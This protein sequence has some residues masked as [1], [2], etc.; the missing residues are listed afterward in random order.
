M[1]FRRRF[2]PRKKR[3]S[4]WLALAN[5]QADSPATADRLTLPFNA[6]LASGTRVGIAATLLSSSGI[7]LTVGGESGKTRRIV[8]DVK[9]SALTTSAGTVTDAFLREAIMV[10]ERDSIGNVLAAELDLF[11]NAVLGGEDILQMR[12]S[13]FGAQDSVGGVVRPNIYDQW[14]QDAGL[15]RWDT[16]VTRRL[17]DD[18]ILVYVVCFKKLAQQADP[19]LAYTISGEL[20]GIIAR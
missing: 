1:A 12:E 11:S 6:A 10:A 8:G 19:T 17:D 20:R 13:Y 18:H 4:V 5:F 15:Q 7:S 2:F 14:F 3:P 16:Q 9:V